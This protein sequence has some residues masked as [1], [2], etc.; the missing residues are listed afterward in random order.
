MTDQ[1][2]A[3]WFQNQ[4][5][6][7]ALFN[8]LPFTTIDELDCIIEKKQ[9]L[10]ISLIPKCVSEQTRKTVSS[11][12]VTLQQSV[13]IKY[14]VVT[15]LFKKEMQLLLEFHQL[16]KYISNIFTSQSIRIRQC[17]PHPTIYH[18]VASQLKEHSIVTVETTKE[19]VMSASYA[20]MT[21]I[22]GLVTNSDAHMKSDMIT[23][24]ACVVIDQ[25]DNFQMNYLFLL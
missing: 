11:L 2:S 1:E 13:D 21:P 6:I 15:D 3:D 9:D 4:Y 12:L 18:S 23:N 10:F 25:L 8:L 19:G 24:G 14:I 7:D 16:T 20:N 17:K 22:I 5:I